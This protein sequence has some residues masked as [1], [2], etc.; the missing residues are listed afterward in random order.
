MFKL[1]ATGNDYHSRMRHPSAAPGLRHWSLSGPPLHLVC[2]A[3]PTVGGL[4]N[5]SGPNLVRILCS[6][7][8]TFVRRGPNL[9]QSLDYFLILYEFISYWYNV[10]AF[11]LTLQTKVDYQKGKKNIYINPDM[12]LGLMQREYSASTSDTKTDPRCC[13][14]SFVSFHIGLSRCPSVWASHPALQMAS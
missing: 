9:F 14:F 1:S 4:C 10:H 7:C 6:V 11:D 12:D 8:V 3:V 5:R 13:L 2:S